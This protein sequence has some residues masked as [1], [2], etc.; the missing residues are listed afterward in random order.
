MFVSIEADWQYLALVF[1]VPCLACHLLEKNHR[2]LLRVLREND[3]LTRHI[4]LI[5]FLTILDVNHTL[6]ELF[7]KELL[8][9][10]RAHR[11]PIVL[12]DRL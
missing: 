6:V 3:F 2:A 5:T 12:L 9:C 4:T 7:V 11:A 10:D 8:R 1:M